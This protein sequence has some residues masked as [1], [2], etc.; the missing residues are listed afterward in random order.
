MKKLF[1]SI[2]LFLFPS[3]IFCQRIDVLKIH[4]DILNNERKILVYIPRQYDKKPDSKFEVIYVFDAQNRNY[5]D[6]AYSTLSFLNDSRFPMIVVGVVSEDRNMDFLTGKEYH[7]SSW[8][9]GDYR[10]NAEDF[11]SFISDE[12]IPY[13]DSNYRA[14]PKRIAIGH[15]NGGTFLMYAFAV[16]PQVFDAYLLISPNCAYH[17]DQPVRR[18]ADFDPNQLASE[19]YIYMCNADEGNYWKDW[20][21]ARDKT[22]SLLK[23]RAFKKKVIFE[24]QDFSAFEDHIT[25]FPMGVFNGL[26][27]YLNYQFFNA[28][29][30][31]AYYSELKAK[32]IVEFSPDQLNELASGFYYDGK[33]DET[34]KILHWASQI[35]PESLNLYDNLGEMYQKQNNKLLAL[36]YFNL[37]E[38]K[39]EQHKNMLTDNEYEKLKKYIS[40]RIKSLENIE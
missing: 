28:D 15:S 26:K 30:L 9:I 34:I 33:I 29:N 3:V 39:L 40:D 5:F 37:Y 10:G 19:K 8:P 1:L 12:L 36:E 27:K 18:L 17:K 2:C 38:L 35:F 13:I 22:L 20:V 23:S 16:K 32:N 14:L 24:N 31:I 7:E 11:L 25:V 21:P 4:S 6:Y